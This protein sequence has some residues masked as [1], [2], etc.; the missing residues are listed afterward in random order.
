MRAVQAI[1]DEN[2]ARPVLIGREDVVE[3][4]IRKL[5]LRIKAGE[6]FDLVDPE[7][8]RRY[9]DYWNAYH[10]LMQRKGVTPSDARTLVRTNTT[11]IG[12]LLVHKHEADALVCGT[13]GSYGDHLKHVIDVLGMRPGVAKV[14][15][16]EVVLLN[17]GTVFIVDPYVSPDPTAA[18]IAEMTVLAAEQVRRFGLQP[19]VALLSHSSFGTHQDAQA[20][21][22]RQA[23]EILERLAPSLE[24]E[25][26][27]QA[28]AALSEEI[29]RSVFP[30]SRLRG[31][32]NLLVMP[33]LDAANISLQ[34]LK[35]LGEGVTIGPMLL[36]ARRAAHILTP[37]ATVRGILN[38]AAVAAVDAQ[39][40]EHS[41]TA[42]DG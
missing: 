16:C 2:L 38:M 23:L 11:V 10:R 14:S 33:G 39:A 32:A 18:E 29:R 27:M 21:K 42:V 22:M 35:T 4:R 6:H 31:Q 5:C 12:A 1:V 25:G 40:N 28:D 17:A 13:I 41:M 19:K 24:I 8:D 20:A 36:G 15:A 26:E 30:N 37:S 9:N 7:H 3:R 34:L